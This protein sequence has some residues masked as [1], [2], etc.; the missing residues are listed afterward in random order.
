MTESAILASDLG[1]R[2]RLGTREPYR[3]LRDSIAGLPRAAVRT[4]ARSLSKDGRKK[5]RAGGADHF[6]ALRDISFDVHHGEVLGIIGRNG[7]GKSTLLKIFS[8][9]TEPTAGRAEIRG[10]V[11]SL[12]EVGTGFHPELTGRENIYLNGAILGMRRREIRTKFDE[13]VDFAE[14]EQFLDTPVKHYSRGMYT[15]LA[16]SVAAHLDPEILLVDEVLAVGDLAF[17]AKCL[18]KMQ[19]VSGTGR[20]ILF[21]SH[22]MGAIQRLCT[23]CLLLDEGRLIYDGDPGQAVRTY[24]SDAALR[25]S[26]WEGPPVPGQPISL[27]R[28][29]ATNQDGETQQEFPYEEGLRIV[30]E[31]SVDEPISNSTLWVGIRTVE[32]VWVLGTTDADCDAS[33]L[34]ARTIGQYTA[35]LDVPGKWLN[36]GLYE[37]VVGVTRNSPRVSLQ[38]EETLAFRVLDV[39]TP[40][41]LRSGQSRAG[42]LQPFIHWEIRQLQSE[43]QR[44][45]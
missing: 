11:G 30:V 34:G 25:D 6:W 31:Y 20:T 18:R 2:Y 29:F 5:Y 40:A 23:R 12:L 16:F 43:T 32:N 22:N 37:V 13:I 35:S 28:V 4:L 38:R 9:I 3:A 41:Q 8:Q 39:N 10:R 7:A 19:A 26:V 42:I 33:N 17:Q 45:T 1:K 44:P 15:R 21:V 27:R 14:L 36:A 24:V